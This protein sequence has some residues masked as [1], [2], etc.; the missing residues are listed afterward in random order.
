MNDTLHLL[1]NRRS[2]RAYEAR[3]IRDED[4]DLLLQATLRAPTAGNMMLYSIIEV[5]EPAAK[6]ALARSCDNQPFIA[7]APL[8]L[9]FLADYQR[10]VD[11]FRY[12]GVEELCQRR[13]EPLRVPQEGDLFL[14]CCDALI[15]AQTAVVAAESL[16]IGSCYIGD[17]MENYEIHRDLF[18]L[19][20]Y[21][22]PIC[23]LC[24]GYPTRSQLARTM[25]PRYD[26]KFIVFPDR[27]RRLAPAEFAEMYQGMQARFL[28]NP[29][30]PAGIENVGQAMYRRK[31]SAD[32]SV[33][34]TRSVRAILKV[35][36]GS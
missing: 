5:T 13:G 31:F 26:R 2:I 36:E 7:T 6:D 30:R 33:E 29:D 34:M 28:S 1:L 17:I 16:G 8:V 14:A 3:P 24:F 15:A 25:T 27:Y 12:S 32:F 4:K 19:P 21:V 22:F 18:Q 23:L 9:L 35:W 20:Q 11:Y 10:W